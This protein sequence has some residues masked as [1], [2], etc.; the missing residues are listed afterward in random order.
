MSNSTEGVGSNRPQPMACVDSVTVASNV[1]TLRANAAVA[2]SMTAMEDVPEQPEG[3]P[4]GYFMRDGYLCTLRVTKDGDEEVVRLCPA[5]LVVARYRQNGGK[6][7]GRVILFT[8][9]DGRE[10]RLHLL[11]RDPAKYP[12]DVLSGMVDAGFNLS[13]GKASPDAI[14]S[15]FMAGNPRA[16]CRAS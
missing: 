15:V 5:F 1:I 7:W 14:L 4:A 12:H 8:D 10:H 6:G 13:S 9:P 3:M 11:D 2:V 16:R